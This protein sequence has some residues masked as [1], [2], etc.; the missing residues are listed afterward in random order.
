VTG[1][2]TPGDGFEIDLPLASVARGDYII[3]IVAAA[4]DERARELVPMR[5][6][7]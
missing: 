2:A 3:E 1:S 4:G 5:V 6:A 7:S